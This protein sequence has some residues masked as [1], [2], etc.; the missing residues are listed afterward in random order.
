MKA[1]A[2]SPLGLFTI[3][4][5]TFQWILLLSA[6]ISV[7]TGCGSGGGTQAPKFSGNTS[8]TVLLSST[9]ND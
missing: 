9:A 1:V 4:S 2:S 3:H 7:S 5:L 8:V 6:L